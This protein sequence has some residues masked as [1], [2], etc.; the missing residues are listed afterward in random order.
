MKVLDLFSCIGGHALGLQAAGDFVPVQF[1]EKNDWRRRVLAR[2]FPGVPIHDDVRTYHPPFRDVDLV[3][4]GPPCQRTSVASA[5]HGKRTGESLWPEML[6]IVEEARPGWV[7]VEQPPGNPTWEA[8]VAAGLARAGYPSSRLELSALGLGAPHI[9]RRVF[10]LAHRDLSR[11]ALA[12]E[13][14]PREAE[15][16]ARGAAPGNPWASGVPG[17]LRVDDGLPGGVERRRR[18]EAIGDSNPPIMMSVIGRAIIE[19]TQ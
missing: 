9:R 12:G 11:L 1:V 4:G 16:V 8:E 7:V 19:A 17:T 10:T 2:H 15:R 14:G 3:V 13:A 6:R 5:I 18:I